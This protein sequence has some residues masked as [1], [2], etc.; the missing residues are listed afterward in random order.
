MKPTR[1][2]LLAE[3]E[4]RGS[5]PLNELMVPCAA[6]GCNQHI[7]K[8]KAIEADEYKYNDGSTVYLCSEKCRETIRQELESYKVNYSFWENLRK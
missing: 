6:E 8:S 4:S 2:R 7:F 3:I 5:E 1:K